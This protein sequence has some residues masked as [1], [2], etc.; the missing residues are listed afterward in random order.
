MALCFYIILGILDLT[1]MSIA[2]RLFFQADVLEWASQQ[3]NPIR[4]LRNEHYKMEKGFVA[5]FKMAVEYFRKEQPP[6]DV[7]KKE[8]EETNAEKK[9]SKSMEQYYES[10]D[11]IKRMKW[12]RVT[13]DEEADYASFSKR[14][15]ENDSMFKRAPAFSFMSIHVIK[16]PTV[17]DVVNVPQGSKIITSGTLTNWLLQ[18]RDPKKVEVFPVLPSRER[19][20]GFQV[21]W[22]SGEVKILD[23]AS[24]QEILTFLLT[25]A[26]RLQ[27]VQL[28]MEEQQTRQKENVEKVRI[29]VGA[30]VKFN[31]FDTSFWDDPN[32]K[33]DTNFVNPD[34]MDQFLN[35][36]LKSAFLYRYFFKGQ[37][38]RVVPPGMPYHVDLDKK[39]LQL[40]SNFTEYNWLKAHPRF[41]SIE[42][43]FEGFRRFWWVWFGVGMVVVGDVELL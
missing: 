35:G 11:L 10:E 16:D 23:T 43:V 30:T 40:P 36:M 19:R 8:V 39:E 2:R 21:D 22:T 33:K 38:I 28:K 3:R 42:N 20:S 4:V 18:E 27:A 13:W 1:A 14:I 26:P 9:A 5:Y 37:Q 41:E 15:L 6:Q 29:R 31:R 25:V 34:D 24:A 7:G 12:K 17:S 32:R